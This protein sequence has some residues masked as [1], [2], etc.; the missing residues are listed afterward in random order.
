M[1]IALCPAILEPRLPFPCHLG[2]PDNRK[3]TDVKKA[4]TLVLTV[5]VVALLIS[6]MTTCG[7]GQA[8]TEQQAPTPAAVSGGSDAAIALRAPR[9]IGT[10]G[11]KHASG[12]LLVDKEEYERYP[13]LSAPAALR[14]LSD[15]VDYTDYF[16]AP[17]YQGQQ[18]SC[19]GWSVAYALKS[20][21]EGRERGWSLDVPEHLFS[22]SYVF[23]QIRQSSDCLI[24]SHIPDALNLL[25]QQGVAPLSDFSYSADDCERLPDANAQ[26][27]AQDFRIASWNRIPLGDVAEAKNQLAAGYPIVISMAFDS[28]FETLSGSEPWSY[29]G[30]LVGYHAMVIIGYNDARDAFR[31]INSWGASWGDA[32]YAWISYQ[33]YKDAVQEAYVVQDA[34]SQAQPNPTAPPP[35][36]QYDIPLL[37]AD[38]TSVRF[39]ES[40]PDSV[41]YDQRAYQTSFSSADSRYINWELCL[42]H[43]APG[44][45]VN[46]DIDWVYRNDAGIFGQSTLGTYIPADWTSSCFNHGWGWP[47][48][49]N[50]PAG[51]YT[52]DLY[53]AGNKVASDVFEVYGGAAVIPT[54]RPQADIPSVQANVQSLRFY[55]R[56]DSEVPAEQRDYT[57]QF[58]QS[59]TTYVAWELDLEHPAPG[60]RVDLPI[61]WTLRSDDG[62]IDAAYQ[63]DSYVLADWTNSQHTN[64]A[65]WAA[66]GYWPAGTY[67]VDLYVDDAWVTSGSFTIYQD[68]SAPTAPPESYIPSLQA[69]V[70]GLYFFESGTLVPS[71]DQW[72][73]QEGFSQA[74]A[75]YVN[76]V[77]DL[78]HPSAGQQIDFTIQWTLRSEDGSVD[79]SF[80]QDSYLQPGWTSSYHWSGYGWPD[81][82]NWQ[83]GAYWVTLYIDGNVVAEGSFYIY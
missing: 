72:I 22:P 14:S 44:Q 78:A 37:S 73:Y 34:T 11:V 4:V 70:T 36:T 12:L 80:T 62:S 15:A 77:L 39:Y 71:Y 24:G 69:N 28:A 64:S 74:D 8:T 82:G 42:T 1:T 13:L 19:V 7:L 40:G 49:G 3:D 41:P 47:D 2:N 18:G 21:Q 29:S 5:F 63:L 6:S 43:L 50:W 30:A 10:P 45:Q 81:P 38:V 46:F 68:T 57:D 48:V 53:I 79:L 54:S 9:Q 60:Q 83:A 51:S 25:A 33:A 59:S 76:W 56:G 17:G 55:A 67:T 65:G 31:V 16:P 66:P 75:R 23:N 26:Q 58:P 61:Y 27:A 20:Y 52:V 32:G 35:V